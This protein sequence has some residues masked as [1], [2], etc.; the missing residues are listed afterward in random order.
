M[1]RFEGFK[2]Y[3]LAEISQKLAGR[4][5]TQAMSSADDAAAELKLKNSKKR[6]AELHKT[7]AKRDKGITRGL[8]RAVNFGE[9]AQEENNQIL[10]LSKKT[11]ASYVKKAAFDQAATGATRNISSDA[12][13]KNI[14]RLVKRGRGINRAADKL[15]K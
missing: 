11:L 14:K 13:S 8:K 10:E 3:R 12:H 15:A 2:D 6:R 9:D 4:Y 1:G 7:I 5:V